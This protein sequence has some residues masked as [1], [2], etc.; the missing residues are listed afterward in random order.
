M[1]SIG[2]LS[3]RLARILA[4]V[5]MAAC[6]LADS[7]S[8]RRF[9]GRD[10]L[11]QSQ[12]SA[13]LEDRQ[14]FLWVGTQGGVARMGSG[15]FKVYD[16]ASGLG[17]GRIWAMVEDHEGGV[18]VAQTGAALAR[19]HGSRV[20]NFDAASGLEEMDAYALALSPDRRMWVGTS[21]GVYRSQGSRFEKVLLGAPW[22]T[23]SIRSLSFD[24]AGQLWIG[25]RDGHLG[26]WDGL[27]LVEEPAP[28]PEEKPRIL[29]ST[30]DGQNRLWVLTQRG[31]WIRA[32]TGAWKAWTSRGFPREVQFEDFSISVDGTL[33]IALGG[34]GIWIQ[35]PE[36]DGTWYTSKDGLPEER[37][38]TG[39]R[40]HRGIVWIGTNGEGMYALPLL[41]L[42]SIHHQGG[43]PIGAALAMDE[44]PGRGVLV[45]TGRGL[46]LWQEGNG[47]V[48]RWTVKDGLPGNEIWGLCADGA[49]G[50]WLGTDRG[51][52]HLAGDRVRRI[53]GLK[54]HRV[55]QV[56]KDGATFLAGTDRGICR[57]DRQGKVL[58]ILDLT[59]YGL[60]LDVVILAKGRDAI[61]VGTGKGLWELRDGGLLRV[62]P[63]APFNH[64]EV[65]SLYQRPDGE[66]WVGT[67]KG[68]YIHRSGTWVKRTAPDD[69]PDDYVYFLGDA[70][71]GLVAVGHG[72]GVTLTDGPGR[73]YHLNQ[74]VGL[75]DNE[76]NQGAI[77]LDA[78]GR[79]W[80][81]M[82]KGANFL[83]PRERLK[84][85]GL[86]PPTVLEARQP[87]GLQVTPTLVELPARPE[88]VEFD[89][90]AGLPI[91]PTP[92]VYEVMME[93]L[94]SSW[95]RIGSLHQMRYPRLPGGSYRFRVRATLDGHTW[96]E[97]APVQVKVTRTWLEHPVGKGA[98]A[99]AG[100]A[101]VTLLI[102]WR[103]ARL[104]AQALE[105]EARVEDRTRSLDARNQELMEA[106]RLVHETLESKLA[107]T[108]MVVHDL[109]SPVTT[110][111]L[112]LEQ[113]GAEAQDRGAQPPRQVGL[114]AQE[115]QRLETLLHRLLDQA[116][117]EALEQSFHVTT[118]TP[119]A[120]L[121][122]MEE[123]LRLKAQSLGI[124]FE[125][126]Q[127]PSLADVTL[128][129]DPL[130]IQQI[131]LNLAGNAMKYTPSGGTVAVRSR[132]DGE[133]WVLAISDTGR[134][135]EPETIDRLFQPFTQSTTSDLGMGWGLGLSIVKRLVEAHQ[136][137]IEVHSV[138]GQGTTFTLTFPL[139]RV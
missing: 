120:A 66:L 104:Q 114:M 40:D 52:A 113:I 132:Q 102:R 32:T 100:L 54:D 37:V 103:T 125:L 36:G 75:V 70:G 58:S 7:P 56:L 133:A 105:L 130:A 5:G 138:P 8:F 76:S 51:L 93:G 22:D 122:G 91:S 83:E 134:G 94:T 15:G 78:K 35:P 123:V 21:K 27:R 17:L 28:F 24:R 79:L 49:G 45:G 4:W 10:G 87:A 97:S 101:L 69:I 33:V 30:V 127:D 86:P 77:F 57:F 85:P 29:R 34:Q 68:L 73:A 59:A 90:E 47:L 117:S 71:Q 14:G 19:I 61:L 118:L 110:L 95:Q 131:V 124:H 128:Q 116:R 109:R 38:S 31:L 48:K 55:Y 16:M 80:M 72:K 107:F 44:I 81:G 11:P 46:F 2:I 60:P 99:L 108:R 41:G 9:D 20:T 106:H 43:L 137:L 92:P 115:T 39:Y 139:R 12:A 18:W 67:A 53:D 136:A 135:M 62:H 23:T 112:L 119:L 26:R 111:L 3:R 64:V 129:A 42:H 98:L 96:V 121:S 1:V 89:F 88:W 65:V 74:S 25:R 50:M 63:E 126:E 6:A 13:F 82:A 84:L